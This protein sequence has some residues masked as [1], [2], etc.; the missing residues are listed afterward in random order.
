MQKNIC[1]KTQ[2][3]AGK[4]KTLQ[5]NV[6]ICGLGTCAIVNY[7][8]KNSVKNIQKK[9]KYAEISTQKN[10]KYICKTCNIQQIKFQNF[11]Q[12]KCQEK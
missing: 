6:R 1:K 9:C 5:K 3:Y 12:T 2:K 7:T 4:L 11:F 8:L 10:V